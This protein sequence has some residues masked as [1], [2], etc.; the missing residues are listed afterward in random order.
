MPLVY[1]QC[2]AV[3]CFFSPLYL[4]I[5]LCS[6]WSLVMERGGK[7]VLRDSI[8]LIECLLIFFFPLV[9]CMS[10]DFGCVLYPVVLRRGRVPY[11]LTAC[12]TD[13]VHRV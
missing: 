9:L 11:W 10:V 4:F 7:G 3:L 1:H 8:A 12:D 5:C 6:A 13:A 2:C